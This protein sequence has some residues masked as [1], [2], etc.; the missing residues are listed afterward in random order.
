MSECALNNLDKKKNNTISCLGLLFIILVCSL[1]IIIILLISKNNEYLEDEKQEYLEDKDV[2]DYDV[3][4][5]SRSYI[6][7]QPN[8][9]YIEAIKTLF[10]CN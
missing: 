1:S 8:K 3:D 2:E 5:A 6:G 10:G 9:I 7:K 4:K